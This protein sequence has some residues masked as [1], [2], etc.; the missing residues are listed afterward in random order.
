MA[1]YGRAAMIMDELENR[2]IMGPSKG[3]NL[4]TFSSISTAPVP[5]AHQLP[6]NNCIVK[7]TARGSLG[8]RP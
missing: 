6:E 1:G 2:G 4:A 7:L 5:T 8:S 3:A